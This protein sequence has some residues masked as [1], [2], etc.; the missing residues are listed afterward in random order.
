MRIMCLM[1][2]S[3]LFHDRVG[4]LVAF[5]FERPKSVRYMG[6]GVFPGVNYAPP[7]YLMVPVP[8][9]VTKVSMGSQCVLLGVLGKRYL[10]IFLH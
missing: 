2:S 3:I 9:H 8:L 7:P 10:T 5:D 1:T 4:T 6:R